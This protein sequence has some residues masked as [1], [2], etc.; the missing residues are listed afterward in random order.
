MILNLPKLLCLLKETPT[1]PINN[2]QMISKL[3]N[4]SQLCCYAALGPDHAGP[5]NTQTTAVLMPEKAMAPA[6]SSGAA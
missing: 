2:M 6:V 4:R 3:N 5:S 1:K